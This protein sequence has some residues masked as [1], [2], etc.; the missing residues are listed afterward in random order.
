MK[1]ILS[2]VIAFV[3][4][5]NDERIDN[6]SLRKNLKYLFSIFVF[7]LA[8]NVLL[9]FPILYFLN[10][11]E[12]LIVEEEID[13]KN[14]TL[15][16]TLI[17]TG[18]LVPIVEE[19]IFRYLLRYNKVFSFFVNRGKWNMYFKYLVYLSILIFGFIHS[20]NYS[21]ESVLFYLFLPV[22]VATQLI[23]GVFL[24][25]LRVRFNMLTSISSHIL[26][27]VSLTLLPLL[28]VFFE[29]PYFKS[30]EDYSVQIEYVNYNKKDNQ[31]FEIDSLGSKIYNIDIKEYSI[32]H[33]LDSLNG[34]KRN[35][36]DYL[37]NIK[38]SSKKGVSLKDVESVLLDYAQSELD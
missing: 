35:K 26:W 11:I 38:L 12:P 19:F 7:E 4:F 15:L 13:Y 3:R 32:N 34:Y 16:G 6:W 21:N 28:I 25:F 20:S 22:I 30:L 18:V 1:K 23:G 29:K 31:V 17:I 36:E 37:I 24:T 14:N 33:I 9:V 5:P 8:L 2:E 10:K 27:N